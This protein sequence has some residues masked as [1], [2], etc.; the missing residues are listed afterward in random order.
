MD[1]QKLSFVVG[2]RGK[3]LLVINGFTFAKNNKVANRTYWCCRMRSATKAAC[4]ARVTTTLKP[5]G[6]HKICITQPEHN[7]DQTYRML[8][9]IQPDVRNEYIGYEYK[10]FATDSYSS[11]VTGKS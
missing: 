6:L 2:Q 1:D 5:N 11:D 9:K 3:S 4:R 10:S 8:K 7:H